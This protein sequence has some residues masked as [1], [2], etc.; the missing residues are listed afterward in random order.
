MSKV[1]ERQFIL[2]AIFD[3]VAKKYSSMEQHM[4]AGIEIKNSKWIFL[5]E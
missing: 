4:S 3:P 5:I 2:V 1:L